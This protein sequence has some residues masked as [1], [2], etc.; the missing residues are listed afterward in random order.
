MATKETTRGKRPSV[1][2]RENGQQKSGIMQLAEAGICFLL[3]AILSSAQIFGRCTPFGVAAVAAAGS[4]INGFSTLIGT[5]AGYLLFQGV[6]GGL[7]YAAASV[8]TYAV[9][10]AFYDFPLS[11]QRWF[12]P[13]VAALF[14]G[15][16][17]FIHL[18][19]G[20]WFGD[21][22]IFYC[23]ELFLIAA[24]TYYYRGAF[25]APVSWKDS[26]EQLTFQQR[27]GLLTLGGTG[28]IAL[29]GVE[30]FGEFSIGRIVAAIVVMM[31]ARKGQNAGLLGGVSVGMV[32]DLASGRGPY[33]SM[34]YAI[35][36]LASGLCWNRSK[37]AS[38][39]A[40]V[41]ANGAAVLWTW[42]SGMRI[43]LLYEVFVASVLFFVLPQRVGQTTG[44]MLAI[45]K[46]RNTEWEKAKETAAR[47]MRATANAFREVYESIRE[48]FHQENTSVED[49]TVIFRQTADRQCRR[50]SA[51]ETCWQKEYNSTQQVLNDAVGAMI[52]RGKA[53]AND[54]SG[55][56]RS[57]CIHF[58][59]FLKIV[60]EELM[61]FLYRRQYQS[62]MQ[63]NRAA[64]CRQY[65]QLDQI[66]DKAATELS[67]ELTP[68]LPRET[69][70]KKFLRSKGLAEDGT[71]YFD[72]KGHL[73]VEVPAYA[74]I[75]TEEGREKLSSLLGVTLRGPEESEEGRLIFHQAEPFMATASV[76]GKNKAGE[77]VS[78]DTGT[79][80]RREDGLLCILLCD[81]MGSGAEARK[82]SGLAVRLLQ[83][84]LKAGVEP[85][86]ALCTVNS[87][88]ALKGEESG[89]CTTVDL[90]TIEL[91]TGLCS[92]YKFGA[93]PTY[94]RK[95]SKVS[96]ITGSALPAGIMAGDDVKP[97]VTRFRAGEGDW[98]LLLSDG[99]VGGESDDWL[100][101]AFV[102]YEGHSPGELANKLLGLSVKENESTD[103][104]T[105]I[106]VRLEK[107]A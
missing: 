96:C 21:D 42:E 88:L 92:V 105:V 32:M 102:G 75:E 36:G 51:R 103:D 61:A 17:R 30:V 44:E 8:L 84:F 48:I 12:F 6:E 64:L 19:S 54:F 43:G 82:E 101:E 76:S 97:D 80:F 81:G 94:L 34:T 107:R 33:Y 59:D 11:R 16:S 71:V 29:S 106:A 77:S 37:L 90:L 69:K 60:N 91:F 10:F 100:R 93:A 46:P 14:C 68:D 13:A 22:V 86:A 74:K 15:I 41:A 35:A 55:H 38:A 99:L 4:G 3:G 5:V 98:I 57:R 53:V 73:R 40:Y 56:F 23:T 45:R 47:H 26:L 18:S 95:N 1:R 78:G 89:G 63:E 20:G 27:L 79:W 9:A 70:L 67:A 24:A 31:V 39:I 58:P 49:V 2:F 72:G 87:A 104:S 65:A 52:E 25:E 28:L 62:R 66:L 85:E 83:N 50:C 7:H